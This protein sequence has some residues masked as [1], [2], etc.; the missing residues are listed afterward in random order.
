MYETML[1]E[2]IRPATQHFAKMLQSTLGTDRYVQKLVKPA[3]TAIDHLIRLTWLEAASGV[4]TDDPGLRLTDLGRALLR[5]RDQDSPTDEGVSVVVLQ[6]HDPLAYPILVGQLANAGAGLLAD[7][8]LKIDGLNRLVVST[9]L[10]R[11]LVSGKS[12]NNGELSAM[13]TYLDSSS[14]PRPIEVRKSTE[15]HD[16]VL[17]NEDGAVLTIGTSLNGIGRTTTVMTPMPSPARQSLR[18]EYERLWTEAVLVGPQPDEGEAGET[19]TD[20]EPPTPSS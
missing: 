3:E 8:Y 12:N 5:D 17:L 10:T 7:P 9:Q 14:L 20:D 15:L 13:Q 6:A 18:A 19:A 11:V 2:Q 4:A 1:N 16:R